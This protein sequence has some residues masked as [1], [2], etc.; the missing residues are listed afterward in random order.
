MVDIWAV[1]QAVIANVS[2][3]EN[4]SQDLQRYLELMMRIKA[5]ARR[6]II[7]ANKL[8]KNAKF[9]KLPGLAM[10]RL[11]LTGQGLDNAGKVHS[12]EDPY[13]CILAQQ[14]SGEIVALVPDIDFMLLLKVRG[15][16]HRQIT[17]YTKV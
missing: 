13:M 17:F 15:G 2:I 4:A 1:L 9:I 11:Y 10:E 12:S 6:E 14:S 5:P 7:E 8:V 16:Y 3:C